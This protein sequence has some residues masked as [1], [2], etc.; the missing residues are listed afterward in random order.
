MTA[1]NTKTAARTVKIVQR[2]F[3][4]RTGI[5]MV[6]VRF[7][8]PRCYEDQW[9]PQTSASRLIREWTASESA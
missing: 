5:Q 1:A 6:Q 4:Q 3:N 9:I 2:A 8:S 7:I